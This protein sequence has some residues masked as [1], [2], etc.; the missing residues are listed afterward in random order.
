MPTNFQD[1]AAIV[2]RTTRDAPA[3]LE[4]IVAEELGEHAITESIRLAPKKTGFL[5]GNFR[6]G[7]GSPESGL[8]ERFSDG[9]K[10]VLGAS[11]RA[12]IAEESGKLKSRPA[13]SDV[14]IS[15]DV[16]YLDAVNSG[17]PTQEAQ[18]FVEGAQLSMLQKAEELEDTVLELSLEAL[19]G[20]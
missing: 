2:Q 15:N 16:T 9:E 19:D 3:D 18:A 6:L 17:T 20:R 11:D 4:Q 14:H 7:V 8:L 13:F 1:F 10:G 5:R 12:Q